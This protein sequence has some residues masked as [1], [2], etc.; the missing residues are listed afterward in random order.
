MFSDMSTNCDNVIRELSCH[1]SKLDC[2]IENS[3]TITPSIIKEPK[4]ANRIRY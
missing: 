2:Y 4:P 3:I 1:Q